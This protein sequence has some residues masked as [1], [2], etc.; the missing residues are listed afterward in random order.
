MTPQ[1]ATGIV[2]ATDLSPES[3]AVVR[4]AAARA[5]RCACRSIC[6]TSCTC[7]RRCRRSV[8]QDVDRRSAPGRRD[9]DR[10]AGSGAARRGARDHHLRLSRLH[11]RFDRPSRRQDA[12]RAARD[13]HARPGRRR[14]RLHG[15]RR[16]ADDPRRALPHPRGPPRTDLP[17]RARQAVLR[18]AQA[19]GGRRSVARQRQRTVL[20]AGPRSAASPAICAWFTCT[21]RRAST[22]CSASARRSPSRTSRRWS[23]CCRAACARP[24]RRA[25]TGRSA[26]PGEAVLGRRRDPL[27]WEAEMDDADLWSLEPTAGDRR[28]RSPPCAARRCLCSVSRRAGARA[29]RRGAD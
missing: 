26:A 25:G 1:A 12:R 8:R 22:S 19:D 3:D 7:R 9:E 28:R 10:G 24:P 4:V 20:V 5:R 27:A 16:R 15:Q 2:C 14:P 29:R 17:P 18:A 11:R 13:G 21:G 6:S 23:R